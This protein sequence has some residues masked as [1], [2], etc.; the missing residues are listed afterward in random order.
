MNPKSRSCGPPSLETRMLYFSSRVN[1]VVQWPT[2][3]EQ[4]TRS[5]PFPPSPHCPFRWMSAGFANRAVTNAGQTEVFKQANAQLDGAQNIL[6]I[7]GGPVG[8]EMA[9]EIAEEMPG[10]SVTLVT[11]AELMPSPTAAFPD[12]FRDRLK[13]KLEEV[14]AFCLCV[15]LVVL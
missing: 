2:G 3:V 7:G 10:K 15:C 11:S 14:C 8:I 12:K 4:L 1:Y 9:G 5:L 13:K 6:I